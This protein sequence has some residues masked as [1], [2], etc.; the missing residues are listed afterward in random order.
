MDDLAPGCLGRGGAYREDRLKLAWPGGERCNGR[1]V[2]PATMR[3]TSIA[4]ALPAAPAATRQA[5]M[6][7]A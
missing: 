6:K 2:L 5:I 4:E 3:G 7:N 1:P